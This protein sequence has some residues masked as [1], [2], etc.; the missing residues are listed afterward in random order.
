MADTAL[1]PASGRPKFTR[2]RAEW[3]LLVLHTASTFVRH[4][5][6]IGTT[7]YTVYRLHIV[8]NRGGRELGSRYTHM[9]RHE[10]GRRFNPPEISTGTRNEQ[11]QHETDDTEAEHEGGACT[12]VPPAHTRTHTH[13]HTHA[14]S[15]ARN[16]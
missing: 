16:T 11:E 9:T 10:H 5:S 12:S 8:H 2:P 1:R 14:A 13:T 7:L 15:P 4:T 3:R 6:H